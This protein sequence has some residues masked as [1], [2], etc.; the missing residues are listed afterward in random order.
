MNMSQGNLPSTIRIQPTA[1]SLEYLRKGET[2]PNPCHITIH[3]Y[4]A[5]Q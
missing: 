1:I 3:E 5:V 4:V 2:W